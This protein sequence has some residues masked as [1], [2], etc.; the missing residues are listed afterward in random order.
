VGRYLFLVIEAH[1]RL[2]GTGILDDFPLLTEFYKHVAAHD[3]VLN[4]RISRR[5]PEFSNGDSA[6]LDCPK[7]PPPF[8]DFGEPWPMPAGSEL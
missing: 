8:N 5:R 4:W 6:S 1:I 2:G 7:N 3:R